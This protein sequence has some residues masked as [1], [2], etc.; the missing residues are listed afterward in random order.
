VIIG[1]TARQPVGLEKAIWRGKLYRDSCAG[2]AVKL[3]RA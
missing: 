1:L 3:A 2:L